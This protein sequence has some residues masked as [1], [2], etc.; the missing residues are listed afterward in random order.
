M[1]VLTAGMFLVLNG[2]D[3]DAKRYH[4][5]D[6]AI[7]NKNDIYA[8]FWGCVDQYHG[9]RRGDYQGRT[10]ILSFMM[11]LLQISPCLKRT[12]EWL[13]CNGARRLMAPLDFATQVVHENKEFKWFLIDVLKADRNMR[14]RFK[15][16]KKGIALADPS[17]VQTVIDAGVD[18]SNP[19]IMENFFRTCL[20]LHQE[21]REALYSR[22][23]DVARLLLA[24]GANLSGLREKVTS[25][26]DQCASCSLIAQ[27]MKDR[28]FCLSSSSAMTSS[29]SSSSSNHDASIGAMD[30]FHAG[31]QTSRDYLYTPGVHVGYIYF[32]QQSW[33][34]LN[35]QGLCVPVTLRSLNVKI[36][37]R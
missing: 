2:A 23:Y 4:S 35:K 36:V 31:S 26:W 3:S 29:S 21:K 37:E 18:L 7:S 8:S 1:A 17:I 12:R 15:A 19:G 22:L 9:L 11:D 32:M 28:S 5:S 14:R 6:Y 20:R 25:S 33:W 16:L 34:F 27:C 10:K 13:T 30:A 24:A